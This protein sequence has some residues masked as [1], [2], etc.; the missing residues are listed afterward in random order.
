MIHEVHISKFANS[1]KFICE[2][3]ISTHGTFGHWQSSKKF[4]SPGGG[5]TWSPPLAFSFSSFPLATAWLRGP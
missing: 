5:E 4:H 2:M 1:L 3:K